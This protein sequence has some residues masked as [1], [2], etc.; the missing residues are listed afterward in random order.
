[1]VE[2]REDLLK[3]E[4]YFFFKAYDW[5]KILNLLDEK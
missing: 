3:M 2:A 4:D 5:P 1:M